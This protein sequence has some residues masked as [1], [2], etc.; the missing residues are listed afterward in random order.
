MLKV[1]RPGL[2]TTVQDRGR[3]GG[4]HLGMPP[5]GV[6]DAY[7][8]EV[9]AM[10]VGNEHGEACLECTYLGPE[11]EFTAP[12]SEVIASLKSSPLPSTA[13]DP[14]RR[15][16]AIASLVPFEPAIPLV[17]VSSASSTSSKST[18]VLVCGSGITAPSF[19]RGPEW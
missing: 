16:F 9:G 15:M 6:M 18:G 17:N 5:S 13:R 12:P 2:L 14:S 8:Y 4:Y 1:R 10:L 19:M 7:A 11:I 3:I